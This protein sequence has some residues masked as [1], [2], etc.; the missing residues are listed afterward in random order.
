MSLQVPIGVDDF[1]MLRETRLEYVDKS[2]LIRELIDRAGIQVVLISRPRRFG[3]TLNLSMLRCFFEKREED[4]T[5]L[6]E[7]LHIW[8]AGDAYR[9]HFQRY[10]VLYMT[11]KGIKH[12]DFD[13]CWEAIKEKVIDLYNEHRYLLDSGELDEVDARRYRQILDGTAGRTFYDRSLLDLSRHLHQHHGERIVI[14]IYEY[15][16]PIHAGHVHGYSAKVLDF[17]RAFLTEALKGNPHLHKAV[18]TGI[19]HVARESI[20]SGLNN[21]AVF[22]LLRPELSTCFGFTE[23]EVEHLLEKAGWRDRCSSS[24]W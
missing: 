8:S 19:L 13:H 10:P 20:F 11:F 12:A 21:I 18:L 15:D 17:F 7:D 23:P 9:A 24:R 6:F 16:A 14:L 3:K 4:F 2:H 22:S 5:S 1:R